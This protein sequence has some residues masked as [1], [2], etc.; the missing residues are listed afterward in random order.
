MAEFVEVSTRELTFNVFDTVSNQWAVI[1]TQDEGKVNGMTISWFQMGYLWRHDVVTVYVRPQR[2][3]FPL[4]NEQKTFGLCF[5]NHQGDNKQKLGYLGSASGKNE[6]KL[7]KCGFDARYDGETPYIAQADM[8][9][10][11]EKLYEQDI[12]PAGFDDSTID[13][14]EY[15][16]KDYHRMYVAKIVKVLKRV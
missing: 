12:D 2:H 5:F 15:A 10:I 8:V 7:A 6:D 4:I 3:T 13:S 1:A 16:I 14:K 9:F 11:C